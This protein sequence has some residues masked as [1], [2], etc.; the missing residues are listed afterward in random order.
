MKKTIIIT[1]LS[2]L[3]P[4]MQ[5]G[6]WGKAVIGGKSP[7]VEC[8]DV[9]GEISAG[10]MTDYI[11]Y[12]ARF[13][14]DSVWTDVNYTFDSVVPITI[15]A[16]YLNGIVPANF[17][18]LDLY[19]SAALGTYAGFDVDLSYTH[20][21]FPED[22]TAGS[23]GE[24]GLELAR[25][26]GIVDLALGSF[27]NVTL[28][29]WYHEAA[30]EKT[31]GVTDSI[32]LVLTTGVAYSDGYFVGSG[33]NHYF[34]TASLPIELNCRATLTPYIGYNGKGGGMIVGTL[35]DI[36]NNATQPDIL[37]GGVSLSVTF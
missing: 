37:H 11:F 17:D 7:I 28:N 35:A 34:A 8:I 13:A 2:A 36:G 25:S 1:V 19:A 32:S 14:R 16:W 9:G 24:V 6:E 21:F 29:G 18:E 30:I 20:F 5:A 31:F 33:W 10:Y 27:Y 4:A 26:L 22:A 15:G 23:E 12:G 3:V